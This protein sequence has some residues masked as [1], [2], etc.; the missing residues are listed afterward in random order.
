MG[1]VPAEVI[2]AI[3]KL[4]ADLILALGE[5]VKTLLLAQSEEDKRKALDKAMEAAET[6]IISKEFPGI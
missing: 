1:S 2:E 4:P 3:E 5:L 6:V